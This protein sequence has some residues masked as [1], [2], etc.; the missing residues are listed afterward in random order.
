MFI[1]D[2]LIGEAVGYLF[3]RVEKNRD[4]HDDSIDSIRQAMR[5]LSASFGDIIYLYKKCSHKLK[6]FVAKSDEDGFWNYFSEVLDE[7]SLRTFCNESGVCKD[8]RIAQDK[9]LSLPFG[10]DSKSKAMIENFAYQLEAYEIAFISAIREYFSKSEKLDLIAAADQRNADPEN[11]LIIFEKCI[12]GLEKEK[13]K[14]DKLLD[15]I[16]KNASRALF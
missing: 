3:T 16:R 5:G 15:E 1:V 9:L 13:A 11:A 6:R 4:A 2:D 14:V 10:S 12:A 7:G 8:L